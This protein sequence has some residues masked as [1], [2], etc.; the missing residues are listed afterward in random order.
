MA[1]NHRAVMRELADI[2]QEVI[3]DRLP[4][5]TGSATDRAI[6][7]GSAGVKPELPYILMTY[8]PSIDAGYPLI[9]TGL[10]EAEVD[11][12]NGETVPMD[13][14]YKDYLLEFS[15]NLICESDPTTSDVVEAGETL[16]PFQKTD[17]FGILA[18]IRKA[19][20]LPKYKIQIQLQNVVIKYGGN[21]ITSTPDLLAEEYHNIG[22]MTL[23]F[24]GTDRLIDYDSG[25]F[26][27]LEYTGTMI[28]V[29]GTPSIP[30]EATVPPT[31]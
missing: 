28:K 17:C 21:Q 18:D 13:V 26:D 20:N 4:L 3:G 7:I 9:A 15:I 19:I 16:S 27:T 30:I 25:S 23:R 6:Y 5:L 14:Q 10:V 11:D 22:S 2:I 12:G 1:V 24:S 29:D 8:T 31:P